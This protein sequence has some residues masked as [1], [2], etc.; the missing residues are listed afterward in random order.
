MY[1]PRILVVQ[2]SCAYPHSLGVFVLSVSRISSRCFSGEEFFG[3]AK[4]LIGKR[5]D[6][7]L[8]I[9]FLQP[10]RMDA[11]QSGQRVDGARSN[12]LLVYEQDCLATPDFPGLTGCMVSNGFQF[13]YLIVGKFRTD[14]ASISQGSEK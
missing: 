5:D 10:E 4:P 6:T 2:K 1:A 7:F 11:G 12:A 3:S 13:M 14:A 9:A 8:E